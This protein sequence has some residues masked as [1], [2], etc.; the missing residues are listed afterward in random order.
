[1]KIIEVPH[2][3]RP[4]AP[5]RATS[6]QGVIDTK[7]VLY[8][9]LQND[10]HGQ[11]P[12]L[13]RVLTARLVPRLAIWLSPEVYRRM[14]LLVPYARRDP[15]CRGKS[16]A[17]IP[18]EWGSPDQQGY[19][20]D[21]NSLVKGVPRSLSVASSFPLYRSRRIGNGFVAS[22]VWRVINS[23]DG[24]ARNPLTYSFVPNLVWLPRQVAGLSDLE[25]SFVQRFLQRLSVRL[26]QGVPVAV[27][28]R[29]LVDRIWELLPPPDDDGAP[30]PD[31]GSLSFFEQTEDFFR[32]R[33]AIMRRVSEAMAIGKPRGKVVSDRFTAGIPHVPAASRS[34]LSAF[35]S[36]YADAVAS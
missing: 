11:D 15:T 14:P 28:H 7:N 25:G 30:L 21:D 2:P 4:G 22:H 27:G 19:F 32:R 5:R 34:A 8:H 13:F 3:R 12:E 33:T 31:M 1:V 17:G 23:P 16:S 29:G 10:V 9:F 20:R 36:E 26:Y 18:D 6:V 35:L 24:A